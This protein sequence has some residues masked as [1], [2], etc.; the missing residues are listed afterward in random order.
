MAAHENSRPAAALPVPNGCREIPDAKR[1]PQG[2]SAD[3]YA[4]VER[5]GFIFAWHDPE[6]RDPWYEI[7]EVPEASSADWS[8]PDRYE[9]TVRAHGQELGENGIDSAHSA[10]CSAL[11]M[12]QSRKPTKTEP[13]DTLLPRSK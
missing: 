8:T 4:A 1:L 5:N 7:P 6:G 11:R 12:F 13:T 9:W 2:A 10:S 3:V